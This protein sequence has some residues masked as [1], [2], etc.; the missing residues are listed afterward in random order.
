MPRYL[1]S[2]QTPA[3]ILVVEQECD[4]RFED[5]V[6]DNRILRVSRHVDHLER[7]SSLD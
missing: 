7:G 2:Y 3:K 6:L 4:S 1:M 5:P